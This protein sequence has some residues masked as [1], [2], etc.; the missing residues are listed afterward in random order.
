VFGVADEIDRAQER[1]QADRDMALSA[2]RE[3]IR[4]SN[5]PR[6]PRV[7]ESCIDCEEPIGKKRMAAV[8][9]SR[10]KDCA[11]AFEHRM[12]SFAHAVR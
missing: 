8:A 6:D 2:L 12:R 7:N 3:R 11:D 1:E 10:C 9:T 5:L 4:L